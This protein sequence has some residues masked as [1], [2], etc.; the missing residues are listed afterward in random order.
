MYSNATYDIMKRA[1]TEECRKLS[2]Y[3]QTLT[4]STSY[5]MSEVV[6]LQGI[7]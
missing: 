1:H 5:E 6:V 7:H 3:K 2:K 4:Y